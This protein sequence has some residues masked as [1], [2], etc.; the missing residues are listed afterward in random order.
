MRHCLMLALMFVAAPA[1]AASP[2]PKEA[3]Q[4]LDKTLVTYPRQ[5][6]AYTLKSDEYDPE[7]LLAGVSLNYQVPGLPDGSALTIFVFP[8]GR[9]AQEDGLKRAL[10][11]ITGGVLAQQK[12]KVYQDVTM[13][14]VG[15]F[16][17]AAPP[18]SVVQDGD[19]ANPDQPVAAA[20]GVS[21]PPA[22]DAPAAIG[23]DDAIEAAAKSAA[24][25]TM[26]IGR[27]LKISFSYRGEPKQS[28]G[29]AFYRNPFLITVRFTSPAAGLSPEQF[30]AMGDEA[31]RALV[32]RIDIQN[33]GTCG[34]IEVNLPEEEAPNED[35]DRN[36][37]LGLI[38]G[39]G[40]IARENCA[41]SEGDHPT[42]VPADQARKEL[43]YP[44]GLWK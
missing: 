36:G 27:K 10:D 28:L 1:M 3:S 24:A 19:E 30:E 39:L 21:T 44:A 4:F 33:F 40:R 12:N 14:E 6:Q 43:I 11:D 16:S 8:Q 26:T 25:P 37:A 22:T 29:Y 31:V 20:T 9:S 5:V 32:P 13:G 38:E 42:P 2:A 35:A 17:V 41:E 15:E 7:Q 18:P 34:I 23:G